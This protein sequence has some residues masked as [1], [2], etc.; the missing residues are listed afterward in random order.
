MHN[1]EFKVDINTKYHPIQ[2]III[3]INHYC[4]VWKH[5]QHYDELSKTKNKLV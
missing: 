2:N 3:V 5:Q 1:E 4:I